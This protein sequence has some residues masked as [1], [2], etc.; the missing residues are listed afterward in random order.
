MATA[1][2]ASGGDDKA[3]P[4]KSKKLLVIVGALVVVLVSLWTAVYSVSILGALWRL[5]DPNAPMPR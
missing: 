5:R 1:P 3:P 2:E 4:K